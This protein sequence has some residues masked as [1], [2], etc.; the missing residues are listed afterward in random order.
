MAYPFMEV[1][2]YFGDFELFE[3]SSR[4][5]TVVAKSFI[6]AYSIP[7]NDF[8]D[9]V[10]EKQYREP[11]LI[12]MMIRLEKFAKADRECSRAVRRLDRVES[13]IKKVK[14]DAKQKLEDKIKQAKDKNEGRG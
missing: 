3:E 7:R 9:L 14:L 1:D 8:L 2:S 4:R 13:R 11:F 6:V 5:W 10:K 12:N